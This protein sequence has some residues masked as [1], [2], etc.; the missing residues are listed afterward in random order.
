MK[1]VVCLIGAPGS[2]K[3]AVGFALEKKGYTF[4]KEKAQELIARGMKPGL[5]A[6]EGFDRELMKLEF[7]RDKTLGEGL[8]VLETWHP[9]NIAWIQI[10]SPN[11]ERDYGYK[12]GKALE[13]I[14]VHCIM[15]NIDN[16]VSKS[17]MEHI[18]EVEWTRAGRSKPEWLDPSK[19]YD[20]H[21]TLDVIRSNLIEI[22]ENYRLA[23]SVIDASRP[24]E[25][26]VEEVDK[27]I[28]SVDWNEFMEEGS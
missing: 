14:A 24:L 17:R 4:L 16:R 1:K 18:S 2:G 28:K 3:S 10:R 9:G 20:Y 5:Y 25:E 13:N 21:R 11:V 19:E 23:Y 8:Y 7:Q 6:D 27:A 15:L 22:M 12:F 26:V